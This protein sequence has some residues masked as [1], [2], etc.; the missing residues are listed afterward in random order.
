MHMRRWRLVPN[1][2]KVLDF[3][4]D[5]ITWRH[6][7]DRLDEFGIDS[8]K[9]DGVLYEELKACESYNALTGKL[10]EIK[11]LLKSGVLERRYKN[12]KEHGDKIIYGHLKAETDARFPVGLNNKR[13]SH[14]FPLGME[15]NDPQIELL[16][17]PLESDMVVKQTEK[18]VGPETWWRMA[19]NAL[20]RWL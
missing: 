6:I 20:K 1:P 15:A 7:V 8:R 10:F 12:W 13:F 4:A 11:Q 16:T 5:D 9:L 17:Q 3:D 14:R 19:H 18:Q 2:A